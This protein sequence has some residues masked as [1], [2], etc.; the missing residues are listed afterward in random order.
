MKKVLLWCLIIVMFLFSSCSSA[1]KNDAS[2]GCITLINADDS[3]MQST[4]EAFVKKLKM[5]G[6]RTQVVYCDNAVDVQLKQIQMFTTAGADIIAVNCAG[7]SEAYEEVFKIA[8][9][10]GIKV[11]VLGTNEEVENCDIQVKSYD[12]LQGLRMC[13][14]VKEY[15]DSEYPEAPP[16]SVT[17]LLMEKTSKTY[18]IRMCAG[19]RMIKERFLR[20]FDYS[21][22]DFIKEETGEAVY[23]IDEKGEKTK[24]EEPSGGLILDEN[25]YA[26]LNPFY[27]N[28]INLHYSSDRNVN[29]NLEGQDTVDSFMTTNAGSK[30]RIIIS[31]SGDAAVGAAEKLMYYHQTGVVN[32]A[33]EK[34]AVFGANETSTNKELVLRSADNESLLRGFCGGDNIT[35]KVNAMLD[36]I[37]ERSSKNY[38]VVDSFRSALSKDGET[39]GIVRVRQ[40]MWEDFDVFY[41][42]MENEK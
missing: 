26:Q 33:L 16:G 12:I 11:M 13:E 19:Y 8:R 3:F 21:I 1:Q 4:A 29:T 34:L 2:L 28:R 40:V 24:V 32:I 41:N 30:L 42:L 17:T 20:Y 36:I 15:L 37:L 9:E 5:N 6:Y 27:D 38:Y 23:Y 14:L 25:G 35:S 39:V 10:N 31:L 18:Y 22:V 7:N